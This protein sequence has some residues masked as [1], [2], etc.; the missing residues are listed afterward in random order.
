MLNNRI[1]N[2]HRWTWTPAGGAAAHDQ[3][4]GGGA[5]AA[6]RR[7]GR[8][9]GLAPRIRRQVLRR[10]ALRH[11]RAAAAALRQFGAAPGA[12]GGALGQA[13]GAAFLWLRTSRLHSG[14][15]LTWPCYTLV[16]SSTTRKMAPVSIQHLDPLVSRRLDIQV[17][18]QLWCRRQCRWRRARQ[19]R[20]HH[21]GAEADAA[22]RAL[23]LLQG[24][25]PNTQCATFRMSCSFKRLRSQQ[26]RSA[27]SVG[28]VCCLSEVC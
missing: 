1:N 25:S 10:A 22:G 24:G 16:S 2:Q 20:E 23:L 18:A 14:S 6:A 12:A 9:R 8:R 4:G 19:F 15:V 11:L 3:R 13:V 26:A 28:C 27:G 21:G 17:V 7:G 5:A